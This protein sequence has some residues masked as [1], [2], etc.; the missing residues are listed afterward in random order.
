MRR[1]FHCG[2]AAAVLL[3]AAGWQASAHRAAAPAPAA[4][5]GMTRVQLADSA[6]F[7][8]CKK[9]CVKKHKCRMEVGTNKGVCVSRLQ[10]CVKACPK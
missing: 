1:Q 3:L 8:A 2:I 6:A 7:E 9:E 4:A 5:P 10:A